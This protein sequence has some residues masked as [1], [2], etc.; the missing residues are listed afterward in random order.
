MRIS[1]IY[2]ADMPRPHPVPMVNTLTFFFFFSHPRQIAG[3]INF[4][5]REVRENTIEYMTAVAKHEIIHA[6]VS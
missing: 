2:G 5:P 6:L 3:L 1:G 4:C